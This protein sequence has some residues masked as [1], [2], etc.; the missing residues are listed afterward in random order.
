MVMIKICGMTNGEAVRAAVDA[1]ANAIG[2]VFAE[3]VRRVTPQYAREIA[4]TIPPDVR[5]VAVMLHPA[6]KDWQEV[7]EIFQ[8]DTLQTDVD[9]F[10]SLDVADSVEKWPV[11]REGKF[12][13]GDSLPDTFLYEG[14]AS[15]AGEK[16]DWEIAAELATRGHMILAGGLNA[17]NVAEAMRL[18]R[19]FGVDVSSAV[20]SQPG[21][22]DVAMIRKFV[23]A[24]RSAEKESL[25]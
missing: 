7:F 1:G 12:A 4:S 2:F 5:K 21:R 14:K 9:D 10:P 11:L 24:V 6:N 22:K 18:A 20:E 15:G 8:P 25:E 19:P 17:E 16:V 23:D 13:A 3:S